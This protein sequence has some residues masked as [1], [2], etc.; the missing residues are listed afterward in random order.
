MS[1]ET[2]SLQ[3]KKKSLRGSRQ[4]VF[5]DFFCRQ[6]VERD[7]QLH[8]VEMFRVE[9]EP[10]SLGKVGRI[11]NTIPPVRIVIATRSD[12]DHRRDVKRV[13]GFEGSWI[14]LF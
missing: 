12:K 13:Q 3:P 5:K 7:I 11:E 6:A 2:T 1:D 4:P 10:L 8:R 9:L 14:P